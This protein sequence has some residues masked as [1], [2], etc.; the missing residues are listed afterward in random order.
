M[1]PDSLEI[2]LV[3]P[4]LIGDGGIAVHAARSVA[5]LR[6]SGCRVTVVTGMAPTDTETVVLPELA[7]GQIGDAAVGRVRH[8]ALARGAQI[9]HL[10]GLGSARA[11]RALRD[12]VA[13]VVSAHG[14]AGCAPGTRYFGAGRE[15]RRR[16]GHGC[17]AHM[18]VSN[19]KHTWDPR[20]TLS[21]YRE[22]S[23][24]LDALRAA[25]V[26]VVYSRAVSAHLSDNGV[27]NVHVIPLSVAVPDAPP[28]YP[29]GAPRVTF[30][31][32]LS[33]AKGVSVLLASAGRFDAH[34]DVVGDGWQRRALERSAL[35]RGL[36]DRVTFHGWRSAGEIRAV[37]A[38][39]HVAVVPSLWPEPFGMVGIE[40]MSQG[41]PVVASSSGGVGD[42]LEHE[43]TGLIV[44]P[45]N[46]EKLGA[47][48]A[49]L[50]SRREASRAMGLEGH[51]VVRERFTDDAHV[52]ALLAVYG[53]VIR[54]RE[55]A[56]TAIRVGRPARAGGVER[57]ADA[58]L[59]HG[60][61]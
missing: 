31:G 22:T 57:A 7:A 25:D 51:R 18:L 48:I 19:C 34:I 2:V 6:S 15:C 11:V 36:G 60:R 35:R 30:V 41:R 20:S 8:E 40:A 27:A 52:A 59:D 50:L 47:A 13:T 26:T 38:A 54:A 39:A 55:S 61:R 37:H 21:S 58:G 17:V 28:P 32:R 10:H 5:A 49:V 53:S 14:W 9:V 29:R 45:G 43:R 24:R 56:G 16:H 3:T 12:T 4:S 33:A 42:W 44:P 23:D 46:P 1:S